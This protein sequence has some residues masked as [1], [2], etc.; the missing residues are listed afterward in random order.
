LLSRQTEPESSTVQTAPPQA[1]VR[2]T[3]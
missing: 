3:T 2:K 1:C